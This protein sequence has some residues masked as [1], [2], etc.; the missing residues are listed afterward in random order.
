MENVEKFQLSLEK[1]KKTL[2]EADRMIY[3]IYPIIREDRLF[4]KILEEIHDSLINIIKAVLQ[5]E[6][7]Y[8]RIKLYMDA[9]A[10][11]ETFVECADRYNIPHEKIS[12]IKKVFFLFERHKQSPME[13]VRNDKFVIMSDNLRTESITLDILKHYTGVTK[14]ILCKAEAVLSREVF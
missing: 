5:Y 4:I 9:E 2:D 13:F 10:N 14:D 6:Y 8:K 7:L 1:A 12:D 3:T 11:F